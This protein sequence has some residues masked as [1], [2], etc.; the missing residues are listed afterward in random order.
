MVAQ[1]YKDEPLALTMADFKD[2]MAT[3]E[4][5]Q[6]L[7]LADE[8]SYEPEIDMIVSYPTYMDARHGNIDGSHRREA[9]R[10]V[11]F[12]YPET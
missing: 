12:N 4:G 10:V 2:Q 11:K 9:K 5:G 1:S 8:L 7:R 3:F 6:T